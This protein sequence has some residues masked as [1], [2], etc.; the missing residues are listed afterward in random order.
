MNLSHPPIHCVKETGT[1]HPESWLVWWTLSIFSHGCLLNT[2]VKD[3]GTFQNVA[4][5]AYFG[6][7]KTFVWLQQSVPIYNE[8]L[9]REQFSFWYFNVLWSTCPAHTQ[10]FR[11]CMLAW[12]CKA[13]IR[14]GYEVSIELLRSST[15]S[16]VA[17]VA[18]FLWQPWVLRLPGSI[19]LWG[20]KESERDG[21]SPRWAFSI[22]QH[23]SVFLFGRGKG[24]VAH[25][26]PKTPTIFLVSSLT[27][28]VALLMWFCS[29]FEG[30]EFEYARYKYFLLWRGC[31]GSDLRNTAVD[32]VALWFP[33]E[34]EEAAGGLGG[35]NVLECLGL[36][37]LKAKT[38]GF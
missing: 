12:T 27:V 8:A 14:R 22:F 15:D 16:S 11:D 24:R 31:K 7:V 1:P 32:W 23:L 3:K 2:G 30:E 37:D 19:R 4:V 26:W 6:A 35:W 21:G 34:T 5:V 28:N 10:R 33:G 17:G 20:R 25:S 18:C 36:K 29:L 13:R 38:S 9:Q